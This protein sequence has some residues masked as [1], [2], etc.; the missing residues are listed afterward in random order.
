LG[1]GL[2]KVDQPYDSARATRVATVPY[3]LGQR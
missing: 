2:A 3:R 1:F